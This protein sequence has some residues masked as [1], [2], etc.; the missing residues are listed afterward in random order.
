M[1]KQIIVSEHSIVWSKIREKTSNDK[2]LQDV[3]QRQKRKDW[4]KHKSRL[5]I[6]TYY[7]LRNELYMLEE[8]LF[9]LNQIVIPESLQSKLMKAANCMGH[10]GLTKTKQ[11]LRCQDT[12]FCI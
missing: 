12:G 9:I 1:V 11:I 8:V 7:M 10:L 5:E 4:E 3:M 6:A 2:R